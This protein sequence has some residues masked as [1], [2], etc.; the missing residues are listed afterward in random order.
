MTTDGS[1]GPVPPR[2]AAFNPEADYRDLRT[3]THRRRDAEI[4]AAQ[5]A[6]LAGNDGANPHHRANALISRLQAE[7]QRAQ[8]GSGYRPVLVD[9][10]NPDRGHPI[11]VVQGEL[12]LRVSSSS[13]PGHG[14]RPGPGPRAD[15]A[16]ASTDD[17]TPPDVQA[18]I[19]LGR[20]GYRPQIQHDADLG[21]LPMQRYITG[22]KD[23]AQL[24]HDRDQV[25]EETGAEVDVNYVC[26]TG[27]TT[28]D[29]DYPELASVDP[30]YPPDGTGNEQVFRPITVAVIDTGI[31]RENRTDGWLA[32]IAENGQNEDPLDV[33]PADGKL[34]AGAGHGTFVSGVIQQVAPQ[35]D[36]VVYRD[37]DTDG[38]GNVQDIGNAI[39][40]AAADGASIISLSLGT[41][42]VDDQPPTALTLALQTVQQQYPDVL[43]VASAGN[44]GSDTPVFPAAAPG[45]VGVAALNA[46]LSPAPWSSFG[47]WVTCAAVGVGISSTFVE[48]DEQHDDGTSQEFGPDAWAI[49]SGTSFSAPQISAAVARLCQ[50]SPDP[51][52]PATALQQLLDGR[53]TLNGYGYLVQLLPGS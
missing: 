37:M 31:N 48:G 7:R 30:A 36:L 24:I 40:K 39:I 35:C 26:V 52:T 32:S 33:L 47:P 14:P 45:V 1:P 8:N 12:L 5:S 27:Y 3:E 16:A 20:L 25:R 4:A 34:D 29:E 43:V 21:L 10:L 38:M 13:P 6:A 19:L 18:A 49:W 53:T 50:L 9:V 46:D 15:H 22:D 44:N 42:T 11:L 28:K 17:G 51:I 23:A 41:T 2:P